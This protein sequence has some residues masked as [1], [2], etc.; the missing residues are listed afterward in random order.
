[1][2]KALHI[3]TQQIGYNIHILINNEEEDAITNNN[4]FSNCKGVPG[5]RLEM[6]EIATLK[7]LA[8]FKIGYYGDK[9]RPNSKTR[10]KS[11]SATTI[12]KK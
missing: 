3:N 11:N 1:M 10:S 9:V 12:T 8:L 5:M 2:S 6:D 7:K 4:C